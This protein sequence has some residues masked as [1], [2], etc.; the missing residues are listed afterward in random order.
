M[1]RRTYTDNELFEGQLGPIIS[2]QIY[3]FSLLVNG[4]EKKKKT[5]LQIP[6][7]HPDTPYQAHI[8]LI[9]QLLLIT[10]FRQRQK[11]DLKILF[12]LKSHPETLVINKYIIVIKNI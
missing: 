2:T 10:T 4:Q 3:L 7:P 1:E 11:L 9:P 6:H 12:Y 5:A 8:F